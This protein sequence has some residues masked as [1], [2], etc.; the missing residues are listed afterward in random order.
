LP[1]FAIGLVVVIV[2]YVHSLLFT[3]V[4]SNVLVGA[5]AAP[6]PAATRTAPA[7]RSTLAYVAVAAILVAFAGFRYA[8]GS[9]YFLYLSLYQALDTT[10]LGDALATS[11]QGVGFAALMFALKKATTFPYVIFWVSSALTVVPILL[12]IKRKSVDP[13]FALFLYF[14]FGLYAVSFNAV[15]QSIAVS[16]LLLAD[17]YRGESKVK[18]VTLSA[19]AILIHSSAVVLVAIQLFAHFWK[20]TKVSVIALFVVTVPLSYVLVQSGALQVL[21]SALN[22]RYETYLQQADGAGVGT[23]LRLLVVLAL[24]F[25]AL[26]LPRVKDADRYIVFV[27]FSA[28][29]LYL[30]FFT[31]VAARLDLYFSSFFV[32]L[33]PNQ[34]AQWRHGMVTKWI[35]SLFLLVY[36]AIYISSYNAVIPYSVVPDLRW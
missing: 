35:L 25:L 3:S 23:V 15:R 26:S 12:A 32:L 36:F 34:L 2:S 31:W 4:R 5:S 27:C 19:L 24:I 1:Y 29:F 17:T 13:V 6:L 18:Y 14:F 10:S 21:A 16:F 8:T 20:P 33:I 28:I 7:K 11:P 30:G 22:S 9:D